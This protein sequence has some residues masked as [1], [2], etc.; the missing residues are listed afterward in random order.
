MEEEPVT[1]TP[2]VVDTGILNEQYD[3]PDRRKQ[4]QLTVAIASAVS[5]VQPPKGGGPDIVKDIIRDAIIVALVLT[6]L[7]SQWKLAD[8]DH[9]NNADQRLFRDSISCFL[10]ETSRTNPAGQTD[11][12]RAATDI[13]IRCGFIQTPGNVTGGTR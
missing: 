6:C 7:I 9:Q 12:Q 4:D 1:P 2:P 3:G 13:L 8:V 11:P 10:V 5:R